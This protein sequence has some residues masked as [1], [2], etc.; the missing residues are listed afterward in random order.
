MVPSPSQTLPH[1]IPQQPYKEI[2][3]LFL[4][5]YLWF[6]SV[7]SLSS[8]QLFVIPWTA[9]RQASLSITNSQSLFKLMSIESMMPSNH[10]ILC[11]PLSSCLQSFPASGSFQMSQFSSCGQSIGASASASVFPMNIQDSCPLGWTGWISLQSKGLSRVFSN[12]AVQEHQ[13]AVQAA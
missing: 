3:S 9:A 4:F 7:Q 5:H 13:V 2:L 11:H 10:L 6:S 12:T 1:L 8:V